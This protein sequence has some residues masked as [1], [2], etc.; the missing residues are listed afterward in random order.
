MNAPL[1]EK[2]TMLLKIINPW[3]LD[4]THLE[5]ISLMVLIKPTVAEI[6]IFNIVDQME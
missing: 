6:M 1:S 4:L 5:N 3:L 2:Y